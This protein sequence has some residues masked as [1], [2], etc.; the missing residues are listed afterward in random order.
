[1]VAE[2]LVAGVEIGGTKTV[3]LLAQGREIVDL[4]RMPTTT[5]TATLAAAADWL[6]ARSGFAAI[7]IGSFGPVGLNPARADYGHVTVT[8]KP[9]WANTPVVAAFERFG[10][11]IAFDTDVA[12]AALAEGRWGA[13]RGC[14]T[15]VYLTIGTGI[16]AGVVVDGRPV[17]GLI[18]PEAGHIRV[19]RVA[20]DVFAGTCPFHGDCIEGLAAGPA[21]AA[22]AGAPAD[23]LAADHPVWDAVAADLAE[24]MMTLILTVSP[25]R[26]VIGGGVGCGQPHLIPRIRERTAEILAGYLPSL[27]RT[28]LDALIVP[29][30]LGDE[31]G[32]LGA[33]SLAGLA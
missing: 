33:V 19:R 18:H 32:P 11:P 4:A 21:I 2:P 10:V 17:H 22:R 12:G 7:G 24:L 6:A 15:H 9:G 28:A 16:G 29:P 26:I 3:V 23:T 14:A 31:A 25:E 30:A 1:M 5:P 20:G 13:A 27:T 8:P